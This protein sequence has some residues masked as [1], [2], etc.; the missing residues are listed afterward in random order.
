LVVKAVL[1]VCLTTFKR[2]YGLET[3][4]LLG[5]GA[6][7]KDCLQITNMIDKAFQI[8]EDTNTLLDETNRL[9]QQ[10]YASKESIESAKQMG[11]T[12]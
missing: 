9:K 2:E 5:I 10:W 4:L 1:P 3:L 8:V 12:T 7:V 6:E 11:I